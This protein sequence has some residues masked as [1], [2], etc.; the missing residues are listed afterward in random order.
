[1]LEKQ[2]SAKKPTSSARNP[3]PPATDHFRGAVRDAY[4]NRILLCP[5]HHM[6]F[7]AQPEKWSEEVLG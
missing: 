6:E 7:D 2:S 1:M 3:A 4:E 5:T